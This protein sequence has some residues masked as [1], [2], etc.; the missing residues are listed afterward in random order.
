[1][2]VKKNEFRLAEL[3]IADNDIVFLFVLL[4]ILII[5]IFEYFF[6]K[7]EVI[8]MCKFIQNILKKIL[9]TSID[10]IIEKTILLT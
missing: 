4:L 7:I 10:L 3:G 2:G 5:E 8:C 1:M 9:E 6:H